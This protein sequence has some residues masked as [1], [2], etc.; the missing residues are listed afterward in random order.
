MD[1]NK[2]NVGDRVVYTEPDDYWFKSVPNGSTGTI[3]E[4]KRTWCWVDWD[5][6]ENTIYDIPMKD[7]RKLTPLEELL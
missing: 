1:T 7:I 4:L 3:T 6:I 5:H 2:F